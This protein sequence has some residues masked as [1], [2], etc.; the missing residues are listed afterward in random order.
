MSEIPHY[1]IGQKL[2]CVKSL[3]DHGLVAGQVYQVVEQSPVSG[4]IRINHWANQHAGG[5]GFGKEYFKPAPDLRSVLL[6]AIALA[7]KNHPDVFGG[8]AK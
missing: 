8:T 2:V 4:C 7:R 5:N 6:S 1:E 3:K